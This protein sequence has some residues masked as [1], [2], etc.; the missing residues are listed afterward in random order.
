MT[1]KYTYSIWDIRF[2]KIDKDG[3]EETHEDGSV[4]LYTDASGK[5]DYSFINDGFDQD[6]LEKYL[7]EDGRWCS[8]GYQH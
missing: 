4:K 3:Y 8:E 2:A 7:S 5:F 1:K 6:D